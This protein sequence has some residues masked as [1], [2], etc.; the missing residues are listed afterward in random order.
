MLPSAWGVEEAGEW[1]RAAAPAAAAGALRDADGAALLTMQRATLLAM[2]QAAGA[3]A[4][5]AEQ[6]WCALERLRRTE[7]LANRA[8]ALQLAAQDCEL[9]RRYAS[10]DDDQRAVWEEQLAEA[11]RELQAVQDA[12]QAASLASDAALAAAAAEAFAQLAEQERADSL[13]AHRMAGLAPPP[14][15]AAATS[16]ASAASGMSGATSDHSTDAGA[17]SAPAD[18]AAPGPSKPPAAAAAAAA[19]S[20]AAA[21]DPDYPQPLARQH[22]VHARQRGL[23]AVV[24]VPPFRQGPSRLLGFLPKRAAADPKGKGKGPAAVEK[25]SLQLANDRWGLAGCARH[26]R[27]ALSPRRPYGRA[28]ILP[29]QLSRLRACSCQSDLLATL[30]T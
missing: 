4:S 25:P 15:S 8:A 2:L 10:E 28:V 23:V 17:S 18:E 24:Q 20:S 27:V 7:D 29:T 14:A 3:S 26:S 1:L 9:G 21:S 30:S 5:Q 16:S 11:Q 6:A 13:L 19:S 22:L 12:L